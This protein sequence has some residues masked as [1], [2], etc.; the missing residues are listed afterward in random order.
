MVPVEAGDGEIIGATVGIVV[1]VCTTVL[2]LITNPGFDEEPL[3][4]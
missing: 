3:S 1:L 2:E 4:S